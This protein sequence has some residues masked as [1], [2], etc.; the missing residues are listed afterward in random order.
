MRCLVVVLS[1][2]LGLALALVERG[3]GTEQQECPMFGCDNGRSFQA[4][5][6]VA[7]SAYQV[8]SVL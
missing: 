7:A 1:L 3:D 6:I 4:G 8:R 2:G 5:G